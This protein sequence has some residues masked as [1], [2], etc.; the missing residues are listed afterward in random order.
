[1]GATPGP[2]PAARPDVIVHAAYLDFD[3]PHLGALLASLADRPVI[4][5]P[6]LL[7]AAYHARI[8][9]PV[10]VQAARD[11]GAQVEIADVLPDPRDGGFELIVAA[12][13]RRLLDVRG[14]VHLD[15]IVLAAAGT[16]DLDALAGIDAIAAAVGRAEGLR[17]VT[18]YASGAGRPIADAL[19]YLGASGVRNVGIASYFLAPG[20]LYDRISN[21]VA[22]G[23]RSNRSVSTK[24]ATVGRAAMA[25]GWAMGGPVVAA[26]LGD[27]AEIVAIASRRIDRCLI[28]SEA[29]V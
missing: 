12:L 17:C 4:V 20:R 22:D 5:V 18:G 28:A 10:I 7:S 13:R 26:P 24:F 27:T 3:A 15:A 19:D 23:A 29:L 2:A 11:R 21:A 9:I 14:A 1:V 8:D 16:R 25:G 6:L